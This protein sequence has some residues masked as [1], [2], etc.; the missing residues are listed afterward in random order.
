MESVNRELVSVL[1]N[2]VRSLGLISD[3]ACRQAMD[4]VYTTKDFPEFFRYPV[5]LAKE[6]SENEHPP[7]TQ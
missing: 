6:V 4:L 1:L 3:A 5:Y 2:H 7:D